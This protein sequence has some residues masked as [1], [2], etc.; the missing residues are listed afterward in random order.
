M[1][2]YIT[3]GV[4]PVACTTHPPH[5]PTPPT[6]FTYPHTPQVNGDDAPNGTNNDAPGWLAHELPSEDEGDSDFDV[7][8]DEEE[9]EEDAVGGEGVGG[10]E[11]AK[12]KKK[13]KR[14]GAKV[15]E[16]KN[17]VKQEGNVVKEEQRGNDMVGRGIDKGKQPATE[18][19]D[20]EKKG[21]EGV[22]VKMEV[23]EEDTED[24]G[25]DEDEEEEDED[26]ES[27]DAE[28][29]EEETSEDLRADVAGLVEEEL[30]EEAAGPSD[31]RQRVGRGGGNGGAMHT[32]TDA[33]MV[34]RRGVEGN[35]ACQL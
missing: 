2:L 21:K 27:S 11:E 17:L 15:K 7:S 3:W 4:C 23:D 9:E 12:G 8:S 31:R 13:G 34:E 30:G 1:C 22:K 5:P 20:D 10:E 6:I 14:V 26:T 28:D 32:I 25:H 24:T 29:E 19:D 33:G 16:E 35:L 18:Y